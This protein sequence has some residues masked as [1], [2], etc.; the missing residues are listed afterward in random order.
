MSSTALDCNS[1][2]K[3]NLRI[4]NCVPKID[5]IIEKK[6]VLYEKEMTLVNIFLS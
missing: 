4:E 1:I 3:S 6:F 2:N 5:Y